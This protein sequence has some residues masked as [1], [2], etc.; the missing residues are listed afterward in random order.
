MNDA[1]DAPP[2]DKPLRLL[3]ESEA[4]LPP[5]A[6]LLQDA[7]GKV[8]DV[9]YL[10]GRRRFALLVNRFRWEDK[11]RA[12][13]E[14]RGYERVRTLI[15]FHNV[16]A[17][18]ARGVDASA[19]DAAFSLLDVMFI[20]TEECAGSVRILLAGGGEVA[21]EVEALEIRVTDVTRPWKA[22]GAPA[23]ED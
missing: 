2:A 9:A 18:R 21:L 13:K 19:P 8:S 3:V 4:D 20:P 23:H 12:E 5:V 17:A 15:E 14:R 16:L 7:A 22:R 10:R 6:A 1:A 11:A